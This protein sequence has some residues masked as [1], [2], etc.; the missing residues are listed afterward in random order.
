M[1]KIL[2]VDDE[3][4]I[5]TTLREFLTDED[6]EVG[7]AEDANQ[8]METLAREEFDVVLV[9][10][11]MPRITGVGLLK[12]IKRT[13]PQT[14]V[15]LMTGEPTVETAAEAVRAGAFDYLAK[16]VTKEQLLKTVGNATTVK[17]LDDERRR[18]TEE[19]RQHREN[20]ERLVEERTAALHESQERMEL[21]LAGAALGTWDW[22]VRTGEMAFNARW[23][24]MLGYE[25]A[26]IEPHL[27]GWQKL[28]YPDDLAGA[29]AIL[30]AHLEGKTDFCESEHRLRHKSG[31]WIWVLRKGRVIERDTDGKPL[32][33]CG[34]ILDITEHKRAE[35]ERL[36]LEAKLRQS[37]KMEAVGQL[38]GGVAHDFNN[39]LTTILGNVE[40]SIDG[41][42]RELGADHCAVRSM[43]DIEKA[44]QRAATLTRQL[45]TFSRQD[46]VRPEALDLNHILSDLDKMLQRLIPEDIA[47][48]TVTDPKL[49]PVRA[50]AGQLEQV[51]VNLAINAA[52]AMPDGGTLTLETQNVTLDEDYAFSRADVQPGPYVMLAVSDT[53]HGMDAAIRDRIFEPFFTTKPL[54]KGTGLGLA[55]VHGIVTQSGAHIF[56]YSEPGHGTTFK[57][58]LPA[59]GSTLTDK[60][61]MSQP[62]VS[63]RGHETVLLCEDDRPVRELIARLLRNAGY[64]VMAAGNGHEAV[65]AAQVHAGSIDLLM[66]DVIMPDMNGR[67]LSQQLLDTIPDLPTLFISGYTASV[68][69]HHGV[70]DEGV[71]FLEKPFTQRG[72]LAKVRAV[73]G[74]AQPQ[75]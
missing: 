44:G 58:Y 48:K 53:G 5:R 8:A 22:N 37:Q 35:E 69:A 34:T 14:Q 29:E 32:R 24:E 6:Y 1:T 30:N 71:E 39:I 68:I 72:L 49:R 7:L 56:P 70:L 74:R 73:L 18:L 59:I 16:P 47:L 42:R 31:N 67:A 2:V 11:I 75:A 63:P 40:V 10:I 25:L 52:D 57:V 46:V 55:T 9:D 54:D 50:D 17:L 36:E 62:T 45:L 19:N 15:I 26:E 4:S 23:A 12:I 66:T 3:K 38:A 28:V 60:S 65:E 33:A 61:A 51:I 27:R 41:L 21:A 64:T 20:L 43:E 13:S